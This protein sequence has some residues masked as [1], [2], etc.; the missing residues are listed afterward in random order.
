MSLCTRTLTYTGYM[1]PEVERCPLKNVA[2]DNKDRADLA[3]TTA[4]VS[5]AA[6][7]PV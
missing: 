4:A 1:A 6:A 5:V 7:W 3:Y 2:G